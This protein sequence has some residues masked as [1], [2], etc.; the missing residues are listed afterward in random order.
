MKLTIVPF[1]NNNNFAAC[2]EVYN[3]KEISHEF[4][5]VL[6]P[7]DS[8]DFWDVKDVKF[9]TPKNLILYLCYPIRTLVKVEETCNS[10]YEIINFIRRAY[11]EIYK[12]PEK[13][14]IWGHYISDLQIESITIYEN[15]YLEVSIG[16]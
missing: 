12:S 15:K 6:C 14:G 7:V 16:S 5:E 9:D 3:N 10:L 2:A 4:E 11:K 8:K 1:D 13:Y